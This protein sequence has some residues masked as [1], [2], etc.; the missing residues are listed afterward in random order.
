MSNHATSETVMPISPCTAFELFQKRYLDSDFED[1]DISDLS[2]GYIACAW[3]A[4]LIQNLPEAERLI[5]NTFLI[6]IVEEEE[7]ESALERALALEGMYIYL[8]LGEYDIA[9]EEGDLEEST[10]TI[11]S[12]E[13]LLDC[14]RL[15]LTYVECLGIMCEI[16]GLSFRKIM[17]PY[18][19]LN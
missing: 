9:Q 10:S 5:Q 11:L 13:V 14:R 7:N 1:I 8:K 16:L 17:D 12:N 4:F 15:G 18:A 3:Y 19:A 2:S 6:G